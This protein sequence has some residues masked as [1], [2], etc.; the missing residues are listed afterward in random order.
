MSGLEV[1]AS[2]ALLQQEQEP[3]TPGS[4]NLK[5]HLLLCAQRKLIIKPSSAH[6]QKEPCVKICQDITLSLLK[7]ARSASVVYIY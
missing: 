1:T 3:D 7:G 4:K 5:I 2:F 6:Q